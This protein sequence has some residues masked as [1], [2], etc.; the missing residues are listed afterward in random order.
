MGALLMAGLL[1][2]P[3]TIADSTFTISDPAVDFQVID[4]DDGSGEYFFD[5]IGDFGPFSTFADAALGTVGEA[6]SMAEFDISGFSIPSGETILSATLEVRLTSIGVFGMGIN[7]EVPES[8]A[9]HGYIANGV[10]ELSDFEAGIGNQ[11][12]LEPLVDPQ[13]HDIVTFDVT[14]YTADTVAAGRPYLGLM[15]RAATFGGVWV[16]EGQGYPQLIIETGTQSYDIGDM[17]CDGIVNNFD[18]S[19]FIQ[20]LTDP[21]AYELQHP[22]CDR[23]LADVNGDGTVNNFDIGPFIGLL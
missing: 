12:D 15:V 22:D 2:C 19:P 14:D 21:T 10:D 17:N 5:G 16:G 11:L 13:L 20:A 3:A 1:I 7:G 9:V 6:R 8:L 18:I 23:M 4:A